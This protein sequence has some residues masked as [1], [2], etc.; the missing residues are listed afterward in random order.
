MVPGWRLRHTWP[1]SLCGTL[2]RR[3]KSETALA[4]KRTGA[5]PPAGPWVRTPQSLQAADKPGPAADS[6]PQPRELAAMGRGRNPH[7][8]L[9]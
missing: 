5:R 2:L 8:S 3:S 6:S 9:S 4:V 1:I 7:C